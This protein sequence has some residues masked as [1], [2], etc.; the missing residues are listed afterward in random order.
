M[1]CH[2]EVLKAAKYLSQRAASGQFTMGDIVN[3]M[4]RKGSQYAESTIRTH[5]ASRMCRNAPANHQSRS[6]ELERL[7]RGVYRLR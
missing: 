2:D 6:D 1:T 4:Q 7:R 5:V 3:E